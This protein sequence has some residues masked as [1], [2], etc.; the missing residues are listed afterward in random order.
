MEFR[1]LR[2]DDLRHFH[3]FRVFLELVEGFPEIHEQEI[4]E[5]FGGTAARRR[6]DARKIV[7]RLHRGFTADRLRDI[8]LSREIAI[9]IA[10]RHIAIHGKLGHRGFGIA[11]MRETPFCGRDDFL[12]RIVLSGHTDDCRAAE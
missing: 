10:G 9:E 7:R 8:Q 2:G 11:V 6:Q 3:D 12:V 5:P 4:V 1:A